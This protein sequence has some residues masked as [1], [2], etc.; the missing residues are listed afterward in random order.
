MLIPL[1]ESDALLD[2]WPYMVV[3]PWGYC[4]HISAAPLNQ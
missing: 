2:S 4:E 1:L 3:E